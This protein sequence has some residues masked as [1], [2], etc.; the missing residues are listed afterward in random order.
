MQAI[1]NK[2][3]IPT[4]QIQSIKRKLQN[5]LKKYN[6]KKYKTENFTEYVLFDIKLTSGKFR[7]EEDRQFYLD[8]MGKRVAT[9]GP[10]DIADSKKICANEERYEQNHTPIDEGQTKTWKRTFNPFAHEFFKIENFQNL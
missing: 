9:R 3:Y 1:W 10:L 8:Q 7:N 6:Q 4:M 2:A 5:I